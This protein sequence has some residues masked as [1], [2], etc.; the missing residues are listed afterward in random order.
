MT[1]FYH[2]QQK[3]RESNQDMWLGAQVL[4]SV[5]ESKIKHTDL[6]RILVDA[7]LSGHIPRVPDDSDVF[8]RVATAAARKKVPTFDPE[9]FENYLIREIPGQAGVIKKIVCERVDKAN[10]SLGFTD[11]CDLEFDRANSSLRITCGTNPVAAQIAH[12]VQVAYDAERGSLNGYALRELI[13]RVLNSAHAT[14][15]RG[16]G[17]GAYFVSREHLDKIDGLEK[18]AA[19]FTT[20]VQ[21]MVIPFLDDEKRREYVREAFEAECAADLDKLIGEIADLRK[22]GQTISA[23]KWSKYLDQYHSFAPKMKEYKTLLGVTLD[24]VETK[25]K[26]A[27]TQIMQLSTLSR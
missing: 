16:K 17:G 24:T 15:L 22:S 14:N 13:R 3:L 10:K 6:V 20:T 5:E 2:A 18:F 11:L 19:A 4:Y 7:G 25:L 12:E 9:V 21:I 23:D 1:D 27:Q 26:I 8:R